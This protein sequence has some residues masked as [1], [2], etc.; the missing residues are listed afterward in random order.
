MF[1][2]QVMGSVDFVTILN[3]VEI[4]AKPMSITA[5]IAKAM[6]VAITFK[7]N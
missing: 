4:I 6:R 5:E 2:A 1:K 3:P 7:F